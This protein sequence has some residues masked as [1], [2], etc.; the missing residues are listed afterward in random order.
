[1]SEPK[2][3][4]E[5]AEQE[6]DRFLE[7]MDIEADPVDMDEDDKKGFKQQ[8][9]RLVA[10]IMSGSAIIDD[11][12]QPVFTPKRS[13][14]DGPPITFYEPTGA[15]IMAMDR[16][17]KAEDVGKLYATMADM[18]KQPAKRFAS[19]KYPDLRVCI[20]VTTLFLG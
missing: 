4:K 9:S 2:I 17:K 16:K 3:S 5:M 1:M 6:F 15:S 12:G 18:T 10:A 7:A 20:A 11:L 13:G 8:K 19:M 14:E